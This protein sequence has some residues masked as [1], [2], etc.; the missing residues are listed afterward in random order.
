MS[1]QFLADINTPFFMEAE[2]DYEM[3]CDYIEFTPENLLKI[4]ED[5]LSLEA[6]R[7]AAR[8]TDR[9]EAEFGADGTRVF[10]ETEDLA[11]DD[12][13]I[14]SLTDEELDALP[15]S[16][17]KDGE[18]VTYPNAEA[19]LDDQEEAL[20][21]PPQVKRASKVAP[22]VLHPEINTEYRT[23]FQIESDDIGMGTPL[24]RFYH[25]IRAIQLLNK[26]DA[27]SRLATP[28]EQRVLADYVGW[29]GLSEFFKEDNP[30]YTELKNV[31]S[32]EEY[33]SAR[34]ST[35]TAFYTP[36]VVIKA[37]YSALENMHF[38]TGNVLEPSCGIGNFM[39]LVPESMND[40]KFY[41]VEL[42]SISG[43]IAQQLYQK[44]ASRCRALRVQICPTASLT[45]QS[46]M[47]PSGS[48]RYP[49][50]AMT[51]TTSSFTTISSPALWIR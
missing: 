18:V 26:L 32:D 31:L 15:I 29:G 37:V 2:N 8:E 5:I 12:S 3:D 7:E 14:E 22:H 1:D 30:H 4:H 41:G 48:S 10:R 44:T 45:P 34:E 25:N 20:A 23:N 39:G 9:Y 21:S 36:P 46:A 47:S 16:T 50:S 38:Q 42:D 17:V 40:A 13:E 27:E 28:T 33:A 24:E 35:L 51:S 11:E 19:L 43:R 6:D 49:T